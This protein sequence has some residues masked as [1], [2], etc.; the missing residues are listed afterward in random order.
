MLSSAFRDDLKWRAIGL[1]RTMA[2]ARVAR[3][4]WQ[5]LAA[6]TGLVH[7]AY[8]AEPLQ[9]NLC[10]HLWHR[11]RFEDP[12]AKKAFFTPNRREREPSSHHYGHDIL[13]KRFMGMPLVGPPLPVLLEHGLKV[14][15]SSR[16][17]SPK[18]WARCGYL[19]MGPLRAQWLRDEHNIPAQAIGPWIRFAKPFLTADQLKTQRSQWGKTLLVVLAHSWD[20]VERSMDLHAC[21]EAVQAIA[22]TENYRQVVWLRHWKDPEA[23]PLPQGWIKA[24][25]GHR[26][27]PWFLDA[28]RTLLDLSDGLATNAFGTHLGYGAALGC[29]LHW[30]DVE[31]EQNLS[32]LSQS[33][34]HEEKAEW[35]E[36]QH[37]SRELR[38]AL[39]LSGTSQNKAVTALLDPYWGLHIRPEKDALRLQLKRR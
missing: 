17:E 7:Q 19:C 15:R 28:M 33:K 14:A 24:C 26:S 27:N 31:A 11:G 34:A 39:T 29:Q 13:L 20:Q 3:S 16:F 35:N 23:L 32:K 6:W 10:N 9:P 37:L 21:I 36:R 25:N 2:G 1:T 8:K 22:R 30:I 5:A 38:Q 4:E 12:Q 18:A